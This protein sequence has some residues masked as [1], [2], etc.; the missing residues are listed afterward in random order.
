MVTVWP[1]GSRGPNSSLAVV[2]PMTVTRLPPSRSAWVRKRPVASVRARTGSQSGVVPT[3]AV[4]QFVG[5]T[6]RDWDELDTGATA[7]MS[8][9]TR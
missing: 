4:V 6:V 5:P 9:A 2:A 8:G 3:T 1:T 7:A